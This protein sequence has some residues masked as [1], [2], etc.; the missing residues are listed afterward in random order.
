MAESIL[1]FVLLVFVIFPIVVLIHELGHVLP[2]LALTEQRSRLRLGKTG[3]TLLTT[4]IGRVDLEWR[5]LAVSGDAWPVG[6]ISRRAA[7]FIT[8][9]GPIASI[10]G[11]ALFVGLAAITRD[12]GLFNVALRWGAFYGFV[13]LFLSAFP[14]AYPGPRVDGQPASA[15]DGYWFFEFLRHPERTTWTPLTP[16]QIATAYVGAGRRSS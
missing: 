1:M 4:S 10:V 6:T 7:L 3:P 8:A 12:L 2:T 16:E 14:I 11:T 13:L 15:S 9:G 5:L